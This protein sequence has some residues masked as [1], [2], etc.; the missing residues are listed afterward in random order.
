MVGQGYAPRHASIGRTPRWT[1]AS[2]AGVAVLSIGAAVFTA[3]AGGQG[4]DGVGVALLRGTMVAAPLAAALYAWHLP[5]YRR[6]A[7]V[8]LLV[9]ITT[10][11]TVLAE[12]P[13]PVPY[14][15]GRIAGWVLEVELVYLVISFP[16]GRPLAGFDVV[17]ARA[18]A[19][20]VA[21]FYFPTTLLAE[22]YPV[23]TP[24]TS[25]VTNCPDNAFFLL[26]EQPAFITPA[27]MFA[28]LAVL[29]VMVAVLVRLHR[30][31]LS[32]SP[33]TRQV[34]MPVVIVGA[35]RVTAVGG[36][37]VA[38]DWLVDAGDTDAI[39]VS[40]WLIAALTPA[41]AL[42]FL[43][44]LMRARLHA[45]HVVWRLAT[46]AQ[47]AADAEGLR[48][49]IAE[50]IGDPSIEVVFPSSCTAGTWQYASGDIATLPDERSGHRAHIVRDGNRVIAAILYD[51]RLGAQ[52]ELLDT[53]SSLAALA[54]DRQRATVA[55][56]AAMAA[57]EAERRRIER[58]LHDGAQQ[59]LI[60]L[61]I[62][63][64]LVEAT[65]KTDPVLAVAQIRNLQ[66]AVE[67]A[68][69][70]LRAFAHG[71]APP[72]LDGG[73]EGALREL[74]GRC[75]LATSVSTR[76]L[77]RYA[78]DVETAVYFCVAEALQNAAKHAVHAGQA[79]VD[80]RDTGG[81]LLF[82]VSDDGRGDPYA[83]I[84]S[85]EGIA[86]MRQ[87]VAA[88]HGTLD[89]TRPAGG[90]VEVRGAIPLPVELPSIAHGE[91]VLAS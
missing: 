59:R 66:G 23:P 38:R 60:A 56:Q 90:G 1:A 47:D 57:T 51:E 81:A 62:E 39:R 58:D 77:S 24:W 70:E 72:A 19:A 13:H 3:T 11:L 67:D 5:P 68:L 89:V 71:V 88:L 48:G 12:S 2:W 84:A 74:A 32:A 25:C 35:L 65:A 86:N 14:S 4:S 45:D 27:R 69:A 36:I 22:A 37:L 64:G 76:D 8:L 91:P 20:I 78:V 42:A 31:A 82:V 73:L 17:L 87:R 61:R 52:P 41:I 34:L 21:I 29:A 28:A 18:M 53:V 49:V 83:P 63:L 26:D 50:A 33:L 16:T 54:L 7:R 30:T 40:A 80:V 9:G 15:V 44:G 10:L 6:F 79:L 85:A 75:P 43:Y 46:R 55:R